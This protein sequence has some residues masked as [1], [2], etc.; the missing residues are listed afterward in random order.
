MS[1]QLLVYAATNTQ[2]T[3]DQRE[4]IPSSSLDNRSATE[5]GLDIM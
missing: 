2:H 5:I 4:Q 1:D 3:K